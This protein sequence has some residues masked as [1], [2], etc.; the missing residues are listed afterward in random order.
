MSRFYIPPDAIKGGKIYAG[1]EESRHIA[2]VMRLKEGDGVTVFDGSGKEY[3]GRIESIKNKNVIIGI[4]KSFTAAEKPSAEISLAQVL[5]KK[6]KMDYIV[7][8]ATE[9]GAAAI[10]PLETERSVI[11]ADKTR[12]VHK[13]ERWQKIAIAAAK[14]CGRNDL[15]EIK[16]I[17]PFK[18]MLRS[19]AD[20]DIVI[21]PCLFEGTIPLK[22]ALKKI[23]DP[24]K[25]LLLIGPEGDFTPDEIARAERE[26]ALLVSLGKLVLKSDTAAV[27]A[28]AILNHSLL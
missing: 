27:A 25:M 28:L 14:Q 20:Y 18:E 10:I 5:I 7:E 2:S 8:K 24:K 3:I 1:K 19:F 23:K 17:T 9:L 22:D 12:E 15:P 4:E 11:H 13:F 6:D 26:G 16:S 21:M